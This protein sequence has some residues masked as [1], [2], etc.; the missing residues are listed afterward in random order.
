MERPRALGIIKY[1]SEQAQTNRTTYDTV[2]NFHAAQM[3]KFE[4]QE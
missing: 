4:C 1:I 2:F 3:I